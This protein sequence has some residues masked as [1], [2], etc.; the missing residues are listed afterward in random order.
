MVVKVGNRILLS[1]FGIGMCVHPIFTE[2][3]NRTQLMIQ[4]KATTNKR[5]VANDIFYLYNHLYNRDGN[6]VKY[7]QI[8]KISEYKIN[9]KIYMGEEINKYIFM[10]EYV[11]LV[12]SL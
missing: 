9:Y 1:R 3:G 8:I 7:I 10:S 2:H 6:Y 5:H 4:T 12:L 11:F